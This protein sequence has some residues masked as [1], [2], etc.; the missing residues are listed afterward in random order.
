[1]PG[2]FDFL[3]AQC[4]ADRNSMY[5]ARFL[6]TESGTVFPRDGLD[7]VEVGNI[8]TPCGI[9]P[10]AVASSRTLSWPLFCGGDGEYFEAVAAAVRARGNGVVFLRR[11]IYATR[12]VQ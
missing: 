3:R 10:S 8:G 2:A 4:A 6:H 9:V 1:M 7:V 5:V 12:P 11:V